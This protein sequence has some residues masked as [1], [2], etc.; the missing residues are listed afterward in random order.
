ML[1]A[2]RIFAVRRVRGH[3]PAGLLRPADVAGAEPDGSAWS[4]TILGNIR[5]ILASYDTGIGSNF[6]L[7][8]LD[9]LLPD[10]LLDFLHYVLEFDATFLYAF[11][12]LLRRRRPHPVG[13]M[14]QFKTRPLLTHLG[15]DWLTSQI[16]CE[17]LV[18]AF[19]GH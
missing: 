7:P 2:G 10:F 14:Q 9:E 15:I 8:S 1:L 4:G 6:S 3:A 16:L 12:V 17:K 5:K 18:L 11:L 19:F 13:S